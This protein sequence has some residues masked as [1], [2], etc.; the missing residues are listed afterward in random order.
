MMLGQNFFANV[1]VDGCR[2]GNPLS[3]IAD[4]VGVSKI[5]LN[6]KSNVKNESMGFK[7]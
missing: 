5:K 3:D 1:I 6:S 2:H 7:S 4:E